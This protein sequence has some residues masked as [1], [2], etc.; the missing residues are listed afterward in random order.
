MFRWLFASWRAR[1]KQR[2]MRRSLSMESLESRNLMAASVTPVGVPQLSSRPG[3]AASLYL[4]FDGNVEAKWGNRANVV[5][6]AYDTDGNKTSFNSS[7]V[8]AIREIW[9]RVAEDYAPF[10]LNV[11]TVP[12]ARVGDRVTAKVAIGG[13][14]SDWY[15][16]SAGGVT[17]VGGFSNSASNVAY[18]FA[19]SVG[20]GNPQYVAE[21]VSHEAGHLFGLEHQATWSG[22]KLVAEYNSGTSAWAPIMGVSYYADRTTWSKGPT[23]DSVTSSQDDLS[24]LAS[25]MNGFGYV[26]DDYGGTVATAATLSISSSRVNVNG[27]IGRN[28]DRDVF[29]FA[30]NGGSVSFSLDVAQYGPN[31]DGV[32]ELQNAA[33]QILV[34]SNSAASYD[35]MLSRTLAAGTY[36]LVVRSSGGYGNLGRYTLSGTV[37][38]ATTTPSSP[39]P[40]PTT[41]TTQPSTT[42]VTTTTLRVVDDGT[43]AFAATGT[44]QTATGAGYASDIRSSA[45]GSGATSTWSFTG[46]AAGQY[47][48][49][50]TWLGSALNATDAP[51]AISSGSKLLSTVRVNQQRAASTFTDGGS[52]W[53]NLGTVTITGNTLTVKLSSSLS[54]RVMAD[55]IR[56]ERVDS[57]SGGLVPQR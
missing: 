39:T 11:T 6:P 49:A 16:S 22:G 57:T 44:W 19:N 10:N 33:G 27:L 13:S 45:A 8:A 53:Q 2:P 38:T 36:Y 46:L 52:S 32:L 35:A 54:G 7:E 56:L 21:A 18:V 40:A 26:A 55:A 43:A 30:T 24:I 15:G 34:S 31:L 41:P 28:D 23:S 5:T 42:P 20:N 9:A 1:G 51:F 14:Y 4:D 3:A 50:A 48:L 25:S 12:P 29:K 17:Y 37:A 47:R